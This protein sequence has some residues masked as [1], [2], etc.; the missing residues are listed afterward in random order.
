MKAVAVEHGLGPVKDY[1]Q[2]QGIHVV[3]PQ[4]DKA[5]PD[6]AAVMCV[7]GADQNIMGMEDVVLNIPIVSCDGLSPEQVY[8]RVRQYLQ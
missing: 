3:E 7:T 8:Q 6:E 4:T 1:L 5:V 2:Q